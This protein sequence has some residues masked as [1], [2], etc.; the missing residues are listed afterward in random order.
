MTSAR[1]E[2]LR[3]LCARHGLLAAI[4]LVQ[5]DPA[6]WL[7]SLPQADYAHLLLLTQTQTSPLIAARLDAVQLKNQPVLVHSQKLGDGNLALLVFAF[8]TRLKE[9]DQKAAAFLQEIDAKN[10]RQ[11]SHSLL[12]GLKAR[13]VE[14]HGSMDDDLLALF[15]AMPEADPSNEATK[16]FRVSKLQ[17]QTLE[18]SVDRWSQIF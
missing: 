5:P 4:L 9:L 18:K 10:I 16:S 2:Y 8:E 13:Q 7:G 6:V 3:D 17:V 1:S 15:S 14:P 11:Q 12:D